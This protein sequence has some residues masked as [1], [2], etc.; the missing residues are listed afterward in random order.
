MW[1]S[2]AFAELRFSAACTS[3]S[4]SLDPLGFLHHHHSASEG[5]QSACVRCLDKAASSAL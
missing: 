2:R 3:A 5:G 1:L 4:S